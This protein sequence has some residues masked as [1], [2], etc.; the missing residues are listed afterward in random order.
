MTYEIY[1]MLEDRGHKILLHAPFLIAS[2]LDYTKVA[3][4]NAKYIYT[5]S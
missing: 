5:D 3:R 2:I 1:A 4:F